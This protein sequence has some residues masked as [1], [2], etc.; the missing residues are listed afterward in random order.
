[1]TALKVIVIVVCLATLGLA[2]YAFVPRKP[3]II[4][5]EEPAIPQREPTINEW[6]QYIAEAI[7][8]VVDGP[9]DLYDY[10]QV[11]AETIERRAGDCEDL[12]ILCMDFFLCK[13]MPEEDVE[14]C[15]GFCRGHGHAWIS[16]GGIQFEPRDGRVINHYIAPWYVLIRKCTV[17]EVQVIVGRDGWKYLQRE[18]I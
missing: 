1:M 9:N 10:W 13:G 7:P 16:L 18:G 4:S 2:L 17:K 3:N 8:F 6:L 12:A 15:L 11:P 14:L 5:T